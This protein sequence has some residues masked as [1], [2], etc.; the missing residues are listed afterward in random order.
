M[1]HLRGI[2]YNAKPMTAIIGNTVWNMVMTLAFHPVVLASA[3]DR[4]PMGIRIP[5]NKTATAIFTAELGERPKYNT[6]N[7]YALVNVYM[8]DVT[9]TINFLCYVR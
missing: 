2:K 9:S 4:R 5:A 1:D 8:V 6:S 7:N 3:T